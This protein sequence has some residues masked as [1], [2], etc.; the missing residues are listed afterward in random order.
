MF[1]SVVS[2]SSGPLEHHQQQYFSSRWPRIPLFPGL[3]SWFLWFSW[4]LLGSPEFSWFSWVLLVLWL[5]PQ[6]KDMQGGE[7]PAPDWL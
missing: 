5:L 3:V 2:P 1:V 6:F 4:V 7:A